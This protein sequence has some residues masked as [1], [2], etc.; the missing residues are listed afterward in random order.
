VTLFTAARQFAWT[1][2]PEIWLCEACAILWLIIRA[3]R[4]RW[5]R[6]GVMLVLCGLMLNGLVTA[7][8]AGTMP[9]I[10]MPSTVRPVSPMW[11]AATPT[12]RLPFLADQASLG[13]FSVGDLMMLFGG[14]LIMAVCLHRTARMETGRIRTR[15]KFSRTLFSSR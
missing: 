5:V 15:L 2:H 14:I 3:V 7:A 9:V 1:Q 11:H 13:L 10:G 12:T 4:S 8:N 6:A